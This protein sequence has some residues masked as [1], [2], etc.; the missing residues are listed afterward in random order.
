VNENAPPKRDG[1]MLPAPISKKLG[2]TQ[3]NSGSGFAQHVCSHGT[4]RVE[5]MPQGY[6]HHAREVCVSCGRFIRWSA[7]PVN[8]ERERLNAFRLARL[9]MQPGLSDWERNFLRDVSKNRR[10]SP[11]QE[12]L[13]VRLVTQ[14]LEGAP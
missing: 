12:A 7:K 2:L 4:T 9:A 8:V 5:L 14:Y 10:L 13:V 3:P 1:A 6:T 11:K